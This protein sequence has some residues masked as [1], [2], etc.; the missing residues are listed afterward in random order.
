MDCVCDVAHVLLV[1]AVSAR[2]LA[3]RSMLSTSKHLILLI[4][5]AIQSNKPTASKKLEL[6]HPTDYILLQQILYRLAV[7]LSHRSLGCV[8]NEVEG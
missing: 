6:K 4:I 1:K 2:E 3:A 8:H 7:F 5:P